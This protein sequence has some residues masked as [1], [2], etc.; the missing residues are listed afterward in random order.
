ML[1]G[2]AV[3]SPKDAIVALL[4]A[5]FVAL[6]M[7]RLALAVAVFTV[8]T[9]P[10]HLPGSVVPGRRWP[11]PLARCS[12]S[13]GSARLLTRR[14][15]LP[16]LQHARPMLFAAIVGFLVFAGVSV[17]WA[18]DSSQTRTALGR[19]F[20][21]AALLLVAYTAASTPSGFRTIVYGYLLASVVTSRVQ[22][23]LRALCS[24]GPT[25]RGVRPQL[26][27]G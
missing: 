24:R 21:N 23:R 7:S 15:E 20:L 2:I 19:I 11:N 18:T 5:A 26:L 17:L 6:A 14:A 8:L 10:A 9:F 16:L 13:L 3:Y 22:H 12:S 1:G 27:R 4:A 25:R